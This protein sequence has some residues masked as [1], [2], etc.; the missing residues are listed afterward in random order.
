MMAHW[1]ALHSIACP[2]GFFKVH[3]IASECDCQRS[4]E[5]SWLA[6]V[7][8]LLAL[9]LLLSSLFL[10][11]LAV[12][13][14]LGCVAGRVFHVAHDLLCFAFDLLRGAFHLG[15]GITRP[16]ADLAFRTS[17]RIVDRAFYLILIHDS[18]SVDFLLRFI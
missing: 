2:A 17:C 15:V 8:V 10:L 13:I 6:V 4:R 16:L 5:T 3:G 7:S 18:T 11:G 12:N 1:I 9:A 14:V